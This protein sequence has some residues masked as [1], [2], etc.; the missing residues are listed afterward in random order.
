MTRGKP[1]GRVSGESHGMAQLTDDEVELIREL[2]DASRFEPKA[3]RFWTIKRLAEK[4]EISRRH[5]YR[6]VSY[7]QRVA[8]LDDPYA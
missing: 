8:P 3:E 5:V 7:C 4:F 2:Y 6:I 1:R